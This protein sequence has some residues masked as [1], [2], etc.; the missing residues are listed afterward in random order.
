MSQKKEPRMPN[1]EKKWEQDLTDPERDAY[2]ETAKRIHDY[3][4]PEPDT[5]LITA[6]DLAR[7]ERKW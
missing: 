1:W 3:G 7:R 6:I 5:I 2:F 4:N